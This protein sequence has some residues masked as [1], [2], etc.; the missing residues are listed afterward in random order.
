MNSWKFSELPYSRP[1]FEAVKTFLTTQLEKVQQA[2][3]A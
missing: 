2:G 3:S 1:D